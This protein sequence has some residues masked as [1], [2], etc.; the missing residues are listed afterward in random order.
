MNI[1]SALQGV[2][3]VP[4]MQAF[5]RSVLLSSMPCKVAK[6]FSISY[7]LCRFDKKMACRLGRSFNSEEG[8]G[9]YVAIK[10]IE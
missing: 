2:I 3:P 5:W 4:F 1:S 8:R 7:T 10:N 6:R 9:G